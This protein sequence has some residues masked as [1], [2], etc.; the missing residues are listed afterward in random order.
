MQK[1]NNMKSFKEKDNFGVFTSV[2]KEII[3]AGKKQYIWHE[4]VMLVNGQLMPL[5]EFMVASGQR[6]FIKPIIHERNTREEIKAAKKEYAN[7]MEKKFGPNWKQEKK[8]ATVKLF[9][10]RQLGI[11][12]K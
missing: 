3:V 7:F 5:D 8:G 9:T 4:R 2:K 6:V 12:L 11:L 1:V 10:F